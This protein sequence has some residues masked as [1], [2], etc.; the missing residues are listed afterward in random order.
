VRDFKTG[1]TTRVSVTSA[2]KQG[3]GKR[4]SNG[5]NAPVIS[6]DGRY[7]AFHSDMPNLVAGDT[8]KLFDIFVHD[9][10]TGKTQRV[11]VS[12]SGAQANQESLSGAS[13]S[14]D[15]RLV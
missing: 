4:R 14:S 10:V 13:F 11:S 3:V 15:G 6:R 9:R 7:V 8:N 2:G 12:S 5:S 1:K